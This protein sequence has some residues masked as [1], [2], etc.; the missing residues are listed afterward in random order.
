MAK[1]QENKDWFD[2]V[3]LYKVTLKPIQEVVD[4]LINAE[5]VSFLTFTGNRQGG[6]S[7][8]GGRTFLFRAISTPNELFGVAIPLDT[9]LERFLTER[10][11]DVIGPDEQGNRAT[12]I[13]AVRIPI[14]TTNSKGEEE[15]VMTPLVKRF[16]T[17]EVPVM[18]LFN[19]TRIMFFAGNANPEKHIPGNA[20]HTFW[21]DEYAK[22]T[23]S[24]N[25][26]VLPAVTQKKGTVIATSTLNETN[27]DN[28]F[29]REIVM[30]FEKNGELQ[31]PKD[32]DAFCGLEI[33]KK[34][35]NNVLVLKDLAGDEYKEE[36]RYQSIVAISRLDQCYRFMHNGEEVYKR[37]LAD[38]HMGNIS[39]TEFNILYLG[40]ADL[41]DTMELGNFNREVNLLAVPN[42]SK[43][44]NQIVGYDH[45]TGNTQS[46]T[47]AA[48]WARVA[49]IHND[50][51]MYEQF[52]ILDSGTLVDEHAET[53]SIAKK[54]DSFKMPIFTDA[55]LW[56]TRMKGEKSDIYHITKYAKG[57]SK[58]T[59][60][61]GGGKVNRSQDRIRF[62]QKGMLLVDSDSDIYYTNPLDE[63]KPGCQIYIA[64]DKDDPER[65]AQLIKEIEE[66]RK[67]RGR[68]G[69]LKSNK[70]A[71]IDTW[72]AA[73]MAVTA[74]QK[75]GY[76]IDRYYNNTPKK[77]FTPTKTTYQRPY[78]N[79]NFSI[80]Q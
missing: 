62:W 19:N 69:M 1:K 60:P 58:R 23:Y 79:N 26:E 76:I 61:A 12:D 53:S 73:S 77:K 50:N 67:I 3:N 34:V 48:A 9:E 2:A 43:F 37:A 71:V 31:V 18:E 63:S 52:V 35:Y 72:D 28:W 14:I 45:G 22:F 25:R 80:F 15:I 55:T 17:K 64:V 42:D 38:L 40:K 21:L 24:I 70:R 57:L 33:Y 4:K 51:P 49:K 7:F 66:W 5:G 65:N 41:G 75:Q 56:N 39:Q 46:N 13:R 36:V 10:L 74:F 27:P 68:D 44:P 20:Y 30:E 8:V 54:L 47:C 6:K 16:N 59:Y 29:N 11:C 32:P 78:V